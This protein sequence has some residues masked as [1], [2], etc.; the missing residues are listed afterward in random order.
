MQITIKGVDVEVTDAL[1]ALTRQKVEKIA[2]HLSSITAIDI[3]LKVEK[4][5][6]IAEGQVLSPE[7]TLFAKAEHADMYHAIDDMVHKLLAQVDKLK[8]KQTDH[9]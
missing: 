4:H 3:T 9:H 5:T 6:Q 8:G 2:T 1:E 7:H